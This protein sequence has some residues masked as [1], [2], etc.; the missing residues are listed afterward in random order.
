MGHRYAPCMTLVKDEIE[1]MLKF[2]IIY[3]I[4]H[5]MYYF[6]ENNKRK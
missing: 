2:G 5:N 4:K 6:Y 3:P 1:K